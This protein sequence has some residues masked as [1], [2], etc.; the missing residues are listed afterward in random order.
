MATDII[1]NSTPFEKR[2]AFLSN[3][4]VVK[5][6]AYRKEAGSIVGNIY[7]GKVAKV[8]PGMQACFVEIGQEKSAFLYVD[9]IIPDEFEFETDDDEVRD[10]ADVS[11]YK[12]K[13]KRD[14]KITELVKAGDELLVQIVKDP[15][16]T[17]GARV[18]TNITIA[19][20]FLVYMPTV[21]HIGVSRKIEDQDERERLKKAIQSVKSK[22]G[23]Y[24]VR[25]LAEGVKRKALKDDVVFLEKSWK[26][27][28][29]KT[30]K[31]KTGK[32]VY[33]ELDIILKTVR[34]YFS[35]GINKLIID[36]RSDY[37]KV[38]KFIENFSPSLK[39]SI[40]LYSGVD[41]LFDVHKIES[42]LNRA[43]SRKI[44]LKS[45]GSI[46][47]DQTEALVAIDVNTGRY[48]GKRN[49]EDTITKINLEAVEEIA[50]QLQ[51][52]N[53]GG[54][55]VVDFIDMEKEINREKVV[56]AFREALKND[57]AKTNVLKISEFGLVQMTRQRS[58]NNLRQ[59]MASPCPYCEG[60]GFV[61]SAETMA[62]EVFREIKRELTD[63]SPN[64]CLF[65]K[66]NS[67][68]ANC[69]YE[70]MN[71]ILETLEKKHKI[72]IIVDPDDGFHIEQ[73]E[74]YQQ[75]IT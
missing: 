57:K 74:I 29:L 1:V 35:I 17:K 9:D 10:E 8:L 38:L 52:R 47:I 70:K 44:W 26:G 60:R 72:K 69:V 46:V 19:G 63:V 4:K 5:F 68:V 45:G 23:G 49:L 51:I 50:D 11:K 30:K 24:I 32:L 3:N 36:D 33:Q 42:S 41:P 16:G 25:T 21:S 61:K 73:F 59:M 48:V 34:D 56:N 31:A 18:T 66:T 75:E 62:F 54:I 71:K 6:V 40:K 65:V 28:Q 37:R 39:R 55:I 58:S 64:E 53:I 20:R 12:R 43:L 22:N 67:D 7:Q 2:I 13:R 14:V 15:L 27:I